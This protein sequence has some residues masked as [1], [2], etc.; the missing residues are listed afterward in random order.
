MTTTTT[1]SSRNRLVLILL[2]GLIAIMLVVNVVASHEFLTEPF[3]GFNDYATPWEAARSFFYEGVDPYSAQAS[4]NIQ[5]LLYGGPATSDQQP[6]HYA[7]P[8]YTLAVAWPLIHIEYAW[9]TAIWLVVSESLLIGALALLLMAYQWRP[10]PLVLV[11]LVLVSLLSYPGARGLIL[12][13]V[14]HLVYFLLAAL[15][16]SLARS[17]NWLAGFILALTT[18]KPQLSV[19]V[20]AFVVLWALMSRRWSLLGALALTMAVLIGMSF[21]LLPGWVGGFVDQLLLYPSYIEVSTP[22]Q[23]VS[24]LFGGAAR[25]VE[26]ILNV[27]GL[28]LLVVTWWQLLISRHS[29][30]FAWTLMLTLVMSQL[31]GLRTATPHFVV[32]L[33]P[34][35]W[36]FKMLDRQGRNL[37]TLLILL[38]IFLLPWIQ[39][40]LTVDG[41]QENPWMFVPLPF[42]MLILLL[43]TRR[44]WW[45]DGSLNPPAVGKAAALP[46]DRHPSS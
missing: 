43:A 35:I 15:V 37:W 36:Y 40:V 23:V 12:G 44:A 24:W 6:N 21:L 26:L 8:F 29:E 38:G 41:R 25:P 34:L 46:H 20:V 3:P 19:F 7:Y 39:F 14:S 5:T 9:A 18:L 30:R 22:A 45:K 32:L 4:L 31:I 10:S 2:V 27:V 33:I 16:W 28:V 42:V 11:A 17:K 1:P 13:Q